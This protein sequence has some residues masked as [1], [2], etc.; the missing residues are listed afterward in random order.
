MPTLPDLTQQ[1]ILAQQ[2][3]YIPI[4]SIGLIPQRQRLSIALGQPVKLGLV[5]KKN[6]QWLGWGKKRSAKRAAALANY[7]SGSTVQLED[8][9]IR[10]IGLPDK[11]YPVWSVI[12]DA[13]GIYYN[14]Y[15]PSTLEQLIRSIELDATTQQ[16]AQYC[17]ALICEHHLTK[18]NHA[19]DID[20]N[21][22]PEQQHILIVDQTRGDLSIAACGASADSFEQML[23]TA[24]RNHPDAVI[25]VKTHPEVSAQHKQG[26]FEASH[27]HAKIRYITASANP[28]SILK[29]MDEVYVVSSQ[30]GFEALMLGK[31][32]HC[33]GLPWY[34]G[35]G[36][37][38]D[39]YAPLH[40]LKNRRSQLNG[41][42]LEQLFA[43][44]YFHYTR[45][46]DPYTQQA[47]ELETILDIAITQKQWNEKL[48]GNVLCIGFSPWKKHFIRNYLNLP[49]IRL[50]FSAE[51]DAN[52]RHAKNAKNHQHV[53]V[54]GMKQPHLDANNLLPAKLWRMEDGFVR[55]VGLGAK[56]ITPYSLVLDDQG[57][58]YN[59][60]QPSQL[61]NCLNHITLN[62]SQRLRAKA[63]MKAL[64]Q[65]NISKYNLNGA[66]DW[67]TDIPAGKR[68]ILVPGQVS[69]DASI[70]YG[71]SI[72][73]QTNEQLLRQVRHNHPEAYIVY[74]PHPDVV[75]GLRD[76]RIT[77]DIMQ[78]TADA[79]VTQANM[80][81]CLQACDEVH[82]MTS[83]T[84]FEALLR[85][86][87]VYCYGQPFYSGW[88]LTTD[89]E[90]HP[91]RLK[92]LDLETLVYATLISYP[93]YAIGQ[94][95]IGAQLEHAMTQIAIER[96]TPSHNRSFF[97]H[98]LPFIRRLKK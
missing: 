20:L 43:A 35:W 6:R 96:R 49:S 22:S 23:A 63:I 3:I 69:D 83:L 71:T 94:K 70:R 8:G 9:F 93:I 41:Y 88:G 61:E 11:K 82:T 74:K 46:I 15:Q 84:G 54:W 30:M 73:C 2:P 79:I 24:M 5:P 57:I 21:T 76:G 64:V 62:E 47:C 32:V 25:W 98:L 29:Q 65:Q 42:A 44:A 91:R 39:Q 77:D 26:H 28:L 37:T 13:L 56:L 1:P 19:P 53:I 18:Y 66:T 40:I 7:A 38:D 72:Q 16:R 34:A 67:P 31:K 55:S 78:Q 50:T 14:A 17:I 95:S 86:K 92:Q 59:P 58:Y 75:S 27:Q 90:A 12:Y 45:Y 48:A 85:R 51:L 80:S 36:L 60:Q 33:F 81:I 68:I 52:N 4:L 97:T 89:L 87:K 10:S